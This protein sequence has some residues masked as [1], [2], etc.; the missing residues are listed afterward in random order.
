VTS[1][2]FQDSEEGVDKKKDEVRNKEIFGIRDCYSYKE[3]PNT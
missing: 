2:C 1:F 3:E